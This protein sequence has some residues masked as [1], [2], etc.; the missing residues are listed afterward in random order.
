LLHNLGN[1]LVVPT[2]RGRGTIASAQTAWS[3]HLFV[4]IDVFSILYYH[5]FQFYTANFSVTS[6]NSYLGVVLCAE[7]KSEL[8]FYLSLQ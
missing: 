4:R 3:R 6:E 1:N 8:R 5:I 7:L 2:Y